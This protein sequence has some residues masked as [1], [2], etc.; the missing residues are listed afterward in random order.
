MRLD[1]T[2]Y[3]ECPNAGIVVAADGLTIFRE[4]GI[5]KTSYGGGF[6]F[7]GAIYF[8]ASAPSLAELNGIAGMYQWEVNSNEEATWEIWACE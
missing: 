1:G 5:G 3:G 8:E 7:R 4:N 6:S 2:F